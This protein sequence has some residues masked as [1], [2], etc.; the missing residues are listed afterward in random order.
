MLELAEETQRFNDLELNEGL[1]S[2]I[3]EMPVSPW[4]PTRYE[5]D[6]VITP[7]FPNFI[8]EEVDPQV[9]LDSLGL[10]V[11][12]VIGGRNSRNFSMSVASNEEG[13]NSQY[14]KYQEYSYGK[15]RAELGITA[16]WV[17]LVGEH[18]WQSDSSKIID[19][20]SSWIDNEEPKVM[21][22]RLT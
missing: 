17:L 11:M 16:H 1:R 18:T 14:E 5:I 19:A 20:Y 12:V 15:V 22:I 4:V 13:A 10:A 2:F 6:R 7:L 3:V 21:I 9:K 8:G